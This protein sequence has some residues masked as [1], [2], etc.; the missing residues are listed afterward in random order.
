MFV[1]LKH[2]PLPACTERMSVVTYCPRGPL[3]QWQSKSLITT[4]LQVRILR[5]PLLR[6]YPRSC[7]SVS[8]LL[9][10]A[11]EPLLHD[12]KLC[13]QTLPPA[14]TLKEQQYDEKI[15]YCCSFCY[16]QAI[17]RSCR[18]FPTYVIRGTHYQPNSLL[19]ITGVVTEAANVDGVEVGVAGG[20]LLAAVSGNGWTAPWL[21][22]YR[23]PRT[24]PNHYR[25]RHGSTGWK[26]RGWRSGARIENWT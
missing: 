4:G 14:H 16:T 11:A 7:S 5:G 17:T 18:G 20:P 26:R 3:A 2:K 22:H 6:Q 13:T 8:F 24:D 9:H 23:N 15:S 21:G 1:L 19:Q 10:V 25:R 12:R